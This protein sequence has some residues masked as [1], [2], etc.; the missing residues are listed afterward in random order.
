MEAPLKLAVVLFNLGGPLTSADVRPFLFNLFSDRHIINLPFFL[1]LP[2]A[3]F[4][5]KTRTPLAQANYNLIKSG[6]PSGGAPSGGS[7]LLANTQAQAQALEE[8]LG[9]NYSE[10]KVF[11]AMRYFSPFAKQTFQEVQAFNPDKIVL[12]PLYPHYS[13]TTTESSLSQWKKL[14]EKN[15]SKNNNKTHAIC[16]WWNEAG[17]IKAHKNLLQE[18]MAKIN[19]SREN[20]HILFSAHGIPENLIKRGDPYQRHIEESA[21]AIAEA[22]NLN[23]SQWSIS[24]QSRV[25]RLKWLGPETSAEIKRLTQEEKK[26]T[27]F[28]VPLSFVSEHIETLVELDIEFKEIADRVGLKNYIRIPALSTRADFILCLEQLIDRSLASDSLL[29]PDEDS[30]TKTY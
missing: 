21:K 26:T 29:C 9:Q 13:T 28:I 24:Y 30:C 15:L 8:N 17:F 3:W 27:L 25:G 2:L 7:P 16:C 10:V 22:S 4:I 1:R 14:E 12:L 5:A 6:A 20:F 23:S 19:L 18:A 11:I